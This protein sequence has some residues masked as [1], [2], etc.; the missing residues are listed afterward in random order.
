MSDTALAWFNGI[1]QFVLLA[2][3]A[4]VTLYPPKAP[5]SGARH[6]LFAVFCVVGLSGIA[7]NIWQQHVNSVAAAEAAARQNAALDQIRKQG[8]DI[9]KQTAV[10]PSVVVNVPTPKVPLPQRH[11]QV[12]QLAVVLKP[13]APMFGRVESDP[14]SEG[15]A[16]DLRAAFHLAEW[17]TNNGGVILDPARF[18]FEGFSVMAQESLLSPSDHAPEAAD[19][20]VRELRRQNFVANRLTPDMAAQENF[21]RIRV[22]SR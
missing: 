16:S 17:K 7:V 22:G 3:G 8:A 20:M 12:P 5:S 13:L 2:L 19:A 21:I 18:A 11:L 4:Y 10:P 1:V 15:L 6:W 14:S 9:Q